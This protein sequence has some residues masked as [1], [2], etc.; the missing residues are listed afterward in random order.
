MSLIGP[1]NKKPR[2]L[3]PRDG[4]AKKIDAAFAKIKDKYAVDP[5]QSQVSIKANKKRIAAMHKIRLLE[6]DGNLW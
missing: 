5:R 6:S 1:Q 4:Y 3:Q 2:T